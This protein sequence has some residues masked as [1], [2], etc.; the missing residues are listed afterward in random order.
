MTQNLNRR[1]ILESRPQGIPAPE[2]FGL[3]EESVPAPGPGQLLVRNRYLSVDP[4][5]RGWVNAVANYS[6][7][8]GLGDVMRAFA[9]GEV[10]NSNHP[11]YAVGEIVTGL[12]GWQDYALSDGVGLRRVDPALGPISTAVGILGINGLSAYFGLLDAGQPKAGETVVVSTAAGA[13]GSC[14]GQIAGIRGCRAVGLTGNDDKVARCRDEFGFDAAI[15]Y[16]TTDD[17]DGALA[18]ACPDGIDVYFDNTGGP[19][20]DAVLRRIN[21]GARIV[22]CGTAAT[23]NWDPPPTGPRVERHLLVKRARIQG[24]LIFDYLDRFDEGQA[25]LSKWIREGRI[26]YREDITDGIENAPSV[27]AGLYQGRNTGKALIRL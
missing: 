10:V 25:A 20:L 3:I 2:H 23:A 16:R 21:V 12:L 18:A 7:P 19:I 1:I 11:D 27:L 22:I 14:V 4:A 17:L 26:N 8:V 24:F 15:N 6:Q 9:V 5:Q 13:V